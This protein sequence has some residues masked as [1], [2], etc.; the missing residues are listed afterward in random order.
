M[1]KFIV[2]LLSLIVIIVAALITVP[3]IFGE[4]LVGIV[5]EEANK[6]L[7]AELNFEDYDIT[8]FRHFPN[9]TLVLEN[10]RITGKEEFENINLIDVGEFE[11]TVDLSSV[12]SGDEIQLKGLE[13]DHANINVLVLEDGKANY[14]IAKPSDEVAA[15]TEEG[16]SGELKISLQSYSIT[17]TNVVYD[18]KSLGVFTR[19]NN[20]N[21]KGSGDFTLDVFKLNTNTTIDELTVAYEGV[22]YL[23]RVNT[24]LNAALEMDL[25]QMKFTFQENE[26][27]LNELGL[28]FDG[29]VQ[30]PGDDIVF[31][32]DLHA[33]QTDF[34]ALIAMIPQEYTQDLAGVDIK[35]KLALNGKLFGKYNETSMP[36]FDINMGVE[37]G[38]VK[39]PDLPQS[40]EKIAMKARVNSA[41][42]ADYD[43]TVV[44]LS[45]FHMEIAGN[46]IDATLNLKTPISDPAINSKIVA[47]VDFGALKNALPLGSTELKGKLN[48][49][50]TL[51]G[52]MSS[53]DNGQY[54]KF[55][56][57]GKMELADF[58]V[59][60]D[61]VPMTLGI[62]KAVLKFSPSIL[63][64]EQFAAYTAKSNFSAKGGLKNYIGYILD[65]DTITG[66][67]AFNSTKIDLNEF[68]TGEEEETVA[69]S[70]DT[71]AMEVVRIPGNVDFE[72]NAKIDELL[73]ENV[74]IKDFQG[75]VF[76]KNQTV[77]LENVK[78]LALEGKVK[79]D[80]SYNTAEKQPT[81]SF[82]YDVEHL[83]VKKAATSF[84]TI[85][86]LA[87]MATKANGKF[88]SKFSVTGIFDE[89]MNPVVQSMKGG[90]NAKLEN[91][92]IEGFEPINKLAE[93]L[94]IDRLA[95]Q[96]IADSK[97]QFEFQD[98]KVMVKPFKTK[99]G[100]I[101]AEIG[102]STSFTQEIDYVMSL[103]VPREM[104]GS[105]ANEALK[106]LISQAN[107]KGLNVSASDNI[108]LDVKMTNTI[109]NPK[110]ST[111]IRESGKSAVDEARKKL[112][113]ELERRKKEA[114]E[115]AK[116]EIE[117]AKKE[118]E[119]KARQEAERLKAEAE[120][121]ASAAKEKA[122]QEA[123][124]AKEKAKEE[125]KKR[126][127]DMFG[128]DKDGGN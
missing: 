88:S 21:H 63:D 15:E 122:R 90:G 82:A 64:L 102:G 108:K 101:A 36:G 103:N 112:E 72:L 41:G 29:Y 128:K 25:P 110:I 33:N 48:A 40:V 75:K 42:G 53:I 67:L 10:V 14:D 111:N 95:K 89:Q 107:A 99:L 79:M 59:S 11:V 35:G 109:T 30:M 32:L 28:G 8:V 68:M 125:G 51:K 57:F 106:G 39:Y 7:T 116:A 98:G 70:E 73:Y 23:N 44:D 13:I 71:V 87:P 105:A 18:D 5:K 121:A 123:E 38:F 31:D 78:M 124:K 117:K 96:K 81:F 66:D 12:I 20:L 115:K 69:V 6:A 34:R 127:K 43:N 93:K 56:A 118:A 92:F 22:P 100:D 50:V 9:L 52:N 86:Q 55:H 74:G 2:V 17:N 37:N 60:G 54:E 1:K 119:E 45:K 126:L 84:E 49:D 114:E 46:P 94:K 19:V 83:D 58:K 85:Q 113:E 80:G 91:I 97:L 61:S 77:V 3:I 120:K 65:D 24:K 26:L 76:V 27:V 104:F 4:K 16:E 62:Q 47:N